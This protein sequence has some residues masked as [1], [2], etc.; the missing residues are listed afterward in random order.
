MKILKIEGERTVEVSH[1]MDGSR[2]LYPKDTVRVV[3]KYYFFP[4]TIN[5]ETRIGR[6]T[7]EQR[8]NI[9]SICADID[10]GPVFY[11]C[12]HDQ[13]FVDLPALPVA[14]QHPI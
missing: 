13:K 2:Y 3:S 11:N 8:A 4:H 14:A 12:W 9:S 7:L 5:N 1:P 6:Q 10:L